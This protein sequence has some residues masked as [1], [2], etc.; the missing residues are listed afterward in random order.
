[1]YFA[2]AFFA[3]LLGK[4]LARQGAMAKI[5]GVAKLGAAVIAT[6]AVVWYPFL[7]DPSLALK[8]RADARRKQR[9]IAEEFPFGGFDTEGRDGQI[10]LKGLLAESRVAFTFP[11]CFSLVRSSSA[12]FPS[13]GASLRIT[14]QTFGAPLTWR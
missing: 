7:I 10:E 2:P 11:P 14:W 3:H 5:A 1:M 6:F 13:R 12:W 8:V 9:M 4:C